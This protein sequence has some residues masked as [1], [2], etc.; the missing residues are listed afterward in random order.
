V[1]RKR[2]AALL[3]SLAAVAA[4]LGVLTVS[5]YSSSVAQSYGRLRPVIVLTKSLSRGETIS[6]SLSAKAMAVRQVPARF[7]P[8][9][10]ISAPEQAVGLQTVGPMP[11][12]SYLTGNALQPP[13]K[14]GNRRRRLG[15]GRHPV[16][17]AVSG[18]GALTGS[19]G[20]VDV[21]VSSE[22][23]A[24]GRGRTAAVAGGVPLLS[25]GRS[26]ASDAGSGLTQVTLG[27][28]RRQAIRLINA[29]S[30]ARRITLLPVSRMG[31]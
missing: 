21:L 27:L 24:R 25:I 6:G 14:P 20:P 31:R 5:G 30:Y 26:G 18:A 9:A 17:I 16:E 7:V 4:G 28:T 10:A 2:R 12:G 15:Q 29:E 19:A 11:A 3:L 1:S 22:P 8:A 13:K 23:G